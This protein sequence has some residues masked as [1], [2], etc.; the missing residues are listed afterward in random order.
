MAD[1]KQTVKQAKEY[2]ARSGDDKYFVSSDVLRELLK[3]GAEPLGH[4]GLNAP[5]A[6]K[7]YVHTVTYEGVPFTSV[8]EY[9]I[10]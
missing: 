9:P 2:L 3:A 7:G 5:H 6:G 10:E 1:I 4:L 8:S